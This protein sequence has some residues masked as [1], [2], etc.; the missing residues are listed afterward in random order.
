MAGREPRFVFSDQR[1][2]RGRGTPWRT[3][4]DVPRGGRGRGCGRGSSTVNHAAE[5]SSLVA[6]LLPRS[7]EEAGSADHLLWMQLEG[8][9]EPMPAGRATMPAAKS[10]VFLHPVR[11][12]QPWSVLTAG[13]RLEWL[14]SHSS[15]M[16]VDLLARLCVRFAV[17]GNRGIDWRSL[18]YGYRA[19]AL[20]GGRSGQL[21][22]SCFTA[23][24]VDGAFWGVHS[25]CHPQVCG[26][27]RLP[28]LHLSGT[29]P[30]AQGC[31]RA[32]RACSR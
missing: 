8:H 18:S 3:V 32:G 29:A 22:R 2:A 27:Y 31:L 24:I 10:G 20:V 6:G 21:Q 9:L 5:Q 25:F 15:T 26:R 19:L 1:R 11:P 7:P 16:V 28:T 14:P 23:P 12:S 17:V 4:A 30:S 13:T